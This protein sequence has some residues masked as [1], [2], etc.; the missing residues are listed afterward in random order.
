MISYKRNGEGMLLLD[1][2]ISAIIDSNYD[3]YTSHCLFYRENIIASLLY[4]KKGNY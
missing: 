4:L 1:N 3:T 2:G